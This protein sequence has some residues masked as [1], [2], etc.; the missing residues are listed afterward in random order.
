VLD[1]KRLL[2]KSEGTADKWLWRDVESTNF[3]VK[4]T[5]YILLGEESAGYGD[6]F[7]KF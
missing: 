1:N 2:R 5:Y 3:S 7:A 4:A 6:L